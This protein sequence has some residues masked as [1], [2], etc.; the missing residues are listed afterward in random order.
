MSQE[1]LHIVSFGRR[2]E[3]ESAFL[4]IR[5]LPPISEFR[6]IRNM[7][8]RCVLL[9][10][11]IFVPVTRLRND[12]NAV[13]SC[14]LVNFAAQAH[15]PKSE[16]VILLIS[17]SGLWACFIFLILYSLSDNPTKKGSSSSQIRI[18]HITLNLCT[19]A[20]LR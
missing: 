6:N 5:F 7:T 3:L 14:G 19:T 10:Y 15:Y 12:F 8:G 1:L 11:P 13:F 16:Y 20:N 18:P 2:L 17:G 4:S 9:K